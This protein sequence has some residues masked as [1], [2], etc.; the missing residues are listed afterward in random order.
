MMFT[1]ALKK[2][3]TEAYENKLIGKNVLKTEY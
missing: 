3:S 2:H 1:L